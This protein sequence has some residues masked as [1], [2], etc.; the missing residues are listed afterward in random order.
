MIIRRKTSLREFHDSFRSS[1]SE[2][3][4]EKGVL[5]NFEKLTGKH[6]CQ[7]LFFNKVAGESHETSSQANISFFF[8][9]SKTN[10]SF[11]LAIK[12][13]TAILDFR[14][15][16]K[17]RRNLWTSNKNFKRFKGDLKSGWKPFLQSMYSL[18]LTVAEIFL[19]HI[20]FPVSLSLNFFCLFKT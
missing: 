14:M 11:E 18:S 20:L 5:K 3:F 9:K 12:S 10:L 16:S 1:S 13:S 6:L 17:R 7:S 8:Q 2:V 4:C 15:S 19:A